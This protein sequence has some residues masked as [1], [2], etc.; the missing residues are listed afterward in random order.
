MSATRCSRSRDLDEALPDHARHRCE[1][2]SAHVHAVDGVELRRSRSGETLGLVGESGCGKS[3]TGRADRCG[4]IEP[5]AGSVALR[6][7]AT[8]P[9]STRGE[10]RPLRREH[11]DRS[12]RTPTPR[13]TRA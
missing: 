12:S 5:T 10:L 2:R 11:A 7:H 3:T 6:R 9:A 1:R 8:S 13:S 4:C